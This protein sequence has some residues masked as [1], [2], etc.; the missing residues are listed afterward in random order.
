VTAPT[1]SA[2]AP[3]ALQAAIKRVAFGDSLDAELATEA[4][5]IIIAARRPPRRS[6]R[7]SSA[8]G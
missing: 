7:S 8:F 6:R 5:G 2:A 1:A 3:T 4:F